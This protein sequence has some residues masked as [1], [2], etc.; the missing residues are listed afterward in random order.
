MHLRPRSW[1][2]EILQTSREQTHGWNC[3]YQ[4]TRVPQAPLSA[5]IYLYYLICFTLYSIILYYAILCYIVFICMFVFNIIA[6]AFEAL[7]K[8]SGIS[9][10]SAL[11]CEKYELKV[12]PGATQAF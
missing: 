6:N 11:D 12:E 5:I 8:D 10:D 3:P 7:L 9:F 2:M 1:G 4:L